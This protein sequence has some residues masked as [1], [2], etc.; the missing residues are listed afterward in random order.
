M[1]P[2]K[3]RR[4]QRRRPDCQLKAHVLDGSGYAGTDRDALEEALNPQVLGSSPR[5]RTGWQV[6]DLG[7]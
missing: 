3:S 2:G 1:L 7:E 5:G 4:V 6:G